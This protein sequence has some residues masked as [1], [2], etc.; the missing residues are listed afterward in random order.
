MVSVVIPAKNAGPGF[1]H[2]L[3]TLQGQAGFR[4]IEIIVVDSGSTDGTLETARRMGATIVEILPETFSH[5]GSRNLGCDRATGEYVLFMVQDALPTSDRWLRDLYQPIKH[6]GV[7]A[8]SCTEIP[9]EDSDLF[10]RAACWNHS[11]FVGVDQGDRIL[12]KPRYQDYIN[13]RTNANISNVA[14]LVHRETFSKYRFRGEF[15]EDLDLG[16]RLVQDGHTLAL[17]GSTPVIHSHNRSAFYHLKRAYVDTLFQAGLFRDFPVIVTEPFRLIQDIKLVYESVNDILMH[18]LQP[19]LPCTM[20]EFDA[21]VREELRVAV[22]GL[23]SVPPALEQC[24]EWDVE[25]RE[26]IGKIEGLLDGKSPVP[27]RDVTLLRAVCGG[28][29]LVL[30]Y[31]AEIYDVIDETILADFRSCLPKAF[32]LNCGAHLAYSQRTSFPGD[33]LADLRAGLKH[34]V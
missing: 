17:L 3:A 12:E 23:H 9:R 7:V 1:A 32:G 4:K 6:D 11:R 14:C 20:P 5:S 25:M 10:Y 8:S 19:A 26:L 16:L 22:K 31:M 29:E 13:L 2:L 30:A 24:G 33:P 21:L 34:A 28:V 18:G 15:A 27:G